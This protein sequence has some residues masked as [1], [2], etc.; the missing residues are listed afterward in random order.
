VHR[1]LL[2]WARTENEDKSVSAQQATRKPFRSRS[3]L[4]G[5][6]MLFTADRAV[7]SPRTPFL[8]SRTQKLPETSSVLKHLRPILRGERLGFRSELRLRCLVEH[9][10][11]RGP[12]RDGNA[13]L[14]EKVLLAGWRADA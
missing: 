7:S 9:G 2:D 11:S 14:R 1:L 12:S 4:R 6:A 10:R 3:P 13:D 5:N 8:D